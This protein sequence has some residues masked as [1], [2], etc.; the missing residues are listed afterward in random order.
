[1]G[2]NIKQISKV[3]YWVRSSTHS[4]SMNTA[5]FL[6][7][8]TAPMCN[9][10]PNHHDKAYVPSLLHLNFLFL[11]TLKPPFTCITCD[12]VYGEIKLSITH[13]TLKCELDLKK[14]EILHTWWWWW[15]NNFSVRGHITHQALG[16]ASRWS[17][18]K[19]AHVAT[20]EH[21]EQGVS[22]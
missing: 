14:E 1:M 5:M 10:K 18:P 16:R 19:K 20:P 13:M 9:T 6:T 22:Q 12:S 7:L 11:L 15:R 8:T 21:S 2:P 4:F 3:K 17:V